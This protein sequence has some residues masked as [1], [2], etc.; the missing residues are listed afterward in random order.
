VKLA[1]FAIVLGG[2]LF[3]YNTAVISGA[4][5]FLT[6]QFSLTIFQEG[7]AVSSI[8][9]GAL[10]GALGAGALADR[11]GRRRATLAT[12]LV[13]IVG[14]WMVARAS[15]FD[16]FLWGRLITGLG[17]GF[18]S[19]IA[20]LYLAEIAPPKSR[21]AFVAA[22]QLAIT[23]GILAAYA[24]D[25]LFAAESAWRSMFAL[26]LIPAAVQFLCIL[27]SPD[28]PDWLLA[29]GYKQKAVASLKRLHLNTP[30]SDMKA[31][32][33]PQKNIG[34]KGLLKPTLRSV[35]L[36]G[37]LL[38]IFQQITGINTVIYYAPKIF[39]NAGVPSALFATMGVG[40]VNV[41]ATI[42][43]VWL[44]DRWGRRPL[45]LISL[46]G[47]VVSLLVL[48]FAF[49]TASASIGLVSVLS[50]MSYVSFFAIG[51][52]PIMWVVISEIYPLQVRGRAMGIATFANW[53]FNYLVSLTFLDLIEILGSAGT[54][55]LY[56]VIGICALL[57][58]YRFI[59]E[60][61]G[62]SLEEIEKENT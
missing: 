53:L 17:V 60:M 59:P 8:L 52:G 10:V 62:K 34:W 1:V 3:G 40:L 30:L 49:F 4:L 9:I 13:F 31:V 12:A 47:M 36:I 14:T 56:A 5:E 16:M 35:L 22:N 54:F 51:L 46:S 32:S 58:I 15:S 19:L 29:H 43:S 42:I 39:Q 33:A 21:G 2:F 38:S 41:L 61:K 25:Y 20:P 50:L 6:Q 24:V 23:V 48:S 7:L 26:A 44:L 11:L 57:F 37:V 28:S 55:F 45:L 27:I 18:S